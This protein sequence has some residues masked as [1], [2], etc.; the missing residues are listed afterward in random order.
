VD[1]VGGRD[2][3]GT[4]GPGTEGGEAVGMVVAGEEDIAP[5]QARAFDVGDW[6][7][8]VCNVGGEL[9]AVEDVC[10]HDRGPLGEG[11]LRGTTIE[12]PRHGARF[13]VRDGSVKAPP[14]VR[15]VPCVPVRVVAGRIEVHPVGT[16]SRRGRAGSGT[17]R[18]SRGEARPVDR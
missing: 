4:D 18:P 3:A 17:S 11:R 10:P 15:A 1:E 13:D 6:R 8:L 14:A 5:G 12:C 9:Y 16:P 2:G 7:V